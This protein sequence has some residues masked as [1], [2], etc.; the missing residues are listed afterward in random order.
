MFD[1]LEHL[2]RQQEWSERTFGS[3]CRTK[4][5]IQHIQKE[6]V[7]IEQDPSGLEWIDVIILAFDGMWR[8]G[9]SPEQ[10]IEAWQAKQVKNENRIW[11]NW[12]DQLE[13]QAVEHIRGSHD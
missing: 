10:I 11:P 12:Q 7:E 1:V 13:D 6:L 9:Y 4:G 3:G 8:A 5:V 2:R